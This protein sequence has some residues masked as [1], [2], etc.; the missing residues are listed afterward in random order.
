MG[1]LGNAYYFDDVHGYQRCIRGLPL[2][3]RTRWVQLFAEFR[4]L[5]LAGKSLQFWEL[6]DRTKADGSINKLHSP[7]FAELVNQLL[8]LHDIE[9][10]WVSADMAASLLI[11]DGDDVGILEQIEFPKRQADDESGEAPDPDI[12]PDAQFLAALATHV[13]GLQDAIAL[14]A[15]EPQVELAEVMRANAATQRQMQAE[16]NRKHKRKPP[17]KGKKTT[18]QPEK[19]APS[20]VSAAKIQRLRAVYEK[21]RLNIMGH[22]A[23]HQRMGGQ[24]DG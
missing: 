13:G 14:A 24:Q 6:Y 20:E 1:L 22:A 16:Q 4:V 23:K 15:T 3:R 10:E 12:D 7:R 19:V 11:S 21:E 18:P 17:S 8:R 5:A 9:P 2:A